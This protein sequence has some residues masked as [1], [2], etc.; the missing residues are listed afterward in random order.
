MVVDDPA[1]FLGE[2]REGVGNALN[3]SS[4]LARST[5][6]LAGKVFPGLTADD[7]LNAIPTFT[8]NYENAGTTVNLPGKAGG[9][10]PITSVTGLVQADAGQHAISLYIKEIGDIAF[11]LP[12]SGNELLFDPDYYLRYNPD[13]A[14]SGI[15]AQVHFDAFGWREGRAASAAFDTGYYLQNN[16]DVAAAGVNP[17]VHFETYGWREGRAPDA[18][19]SPVAYLNSNPDVAAAGINPLVHY[20]LNG[21]SEG[22]DPGPGF[23]TTAYL[24]A[25]PDVAA[26]GVNPMLHYLEY[27]I[28][29]GRLIA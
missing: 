26:A 1:V 20:L 23:D 9:T 11:R 2:N 29:E 5:A 8:V 21:W 15:D 6:D 19:F 27:G 22:R 16:P 12:G 24:Q 18:G 25:N 13:V 4:V 3:G 28:Q 17:L 7:A 10:G 14:A